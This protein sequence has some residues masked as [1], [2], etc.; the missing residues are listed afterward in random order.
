LQAEDNS[1]LHDALRGSGM[2]VFGRLKSADK[3]KEQLRKAQDL[4]IN[5]EALYAWGLFIFVG[6]PDEIAE[7]KKVLR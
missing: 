2:F 4:L 1:R 3:V 5:Q 7:I 6:D